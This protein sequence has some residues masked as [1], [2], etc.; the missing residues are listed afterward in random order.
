M[1]MIRTRPVLVAGA[2]LVL[3][4][5]GVAVV[6]GPAY[7]AAGT[8]RVS[9]SSAGAP[10]NGPSE[11]PWATADARYVGFSSS[12]TNL[13]PGDTNGAA[14]VFLLDRQTGGLTMVSVNASG[15]AGS[16]SSDT[17]IVSADGR[18]VAFESQ[19]GNL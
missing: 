13:V 2:A 6:A 7:A 12:A 16:G 14:D 17:G 15:Q 1:R 11:A 4:G 18:Y 5:A 8:T 19:A 3:A 10:G 9:S